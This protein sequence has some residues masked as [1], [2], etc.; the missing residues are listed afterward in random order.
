MDRDRAAIAAV[1]AGGEDAPAPNSDLAK[2]RLAALSAA[3]A[4][5]RARAQLKRDIAQGTVSA[6]DV[7]SDPPDVALSW[8]VAELLISQ[9]GWGQRKCKKFLAANTISETK[10]IGDLTTRQRRQM[11]EQLELLRR[12]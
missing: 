5:R 7:L 12:R 3:N 8:P 10:R 1:V 6:A 11:T 2:S 9:T 4:V